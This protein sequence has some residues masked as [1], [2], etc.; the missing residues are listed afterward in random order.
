MAENSFEEQ[1]EWFEDQ[2]PNYESG[3]N[4]K[5]HRPSGNNNSVTNI[6]NLN[7]NIYI[8][9]QSKESLHDDDFHQASIKMPPI[10]NSNNGMYQKSQLV[11][12]MHGSLTHINDNEIGARSS[13]VLERGQRPNM[14]YMSPDK[15]QPKK[16]L[17]VSRIVQKIGPKPTSGLAEVFPLCQMGSREQRE[18][19]VLHRDE[20]IEYLRE[21]KRKLNDRMNYKSPSPADV[22]RSVQHNKRTFDGTKHLE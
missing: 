1:S 21:Q 10:S 5:T 18:H 3:Q 20:T 12:Q 22:L 9:S 17:D 15:I 7:Y 14:K 16:P 13:Q 4:F 8:N 6:N 19:P 2:N 11:Q